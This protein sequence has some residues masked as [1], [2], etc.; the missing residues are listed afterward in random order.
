M[1]KEERNKLRKQNRGT[2]WYLLQ[3]TSS[4][5]SRYSAIINSYTPVMSE[6]GGLHGNSKYFHA[7]DPKNY[8]RLQV[9][10]STSAYVKIHASLVSIKD[11]EKNSERLGFTALF[12]SSNGEVIGVVSSVEEIDEFL[13]GIWAKWQ[14]KDNPNLGSKWTKTSTGFRRNSDGRIFRSSI[15]KYDGGGWYTIEENDEFIV[16][17]INDLSNE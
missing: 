4:P 13:D 6:G 1:N 12:G 14:L 17:N 11:A 7:A 9:T 5:V 8:I 10:E 15:V 16:F 3:K 2:I